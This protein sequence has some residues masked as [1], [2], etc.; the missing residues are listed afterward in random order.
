MTTMEAEWV[1]DMRFVHTSDS[2]HALVTD[3][4]AATG[5]GDTAPSPME[6]VLHGLAGCTGVDVISILRKMKEPV[7][8]LRVVVA[9]ERAD[10]HPRV[11]TRLQLKYVVSG[12]VDENK[13]KRAIG[14]SEKT[15]CSVT[16]MLA[17]TASIDTSYEIRPASGAGPR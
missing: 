8:A 14:L 2:G 5:G 17:K 13:L 6:L 4:A 9:A 15:Y 12:D 11:Y 16:A 7:R 10:E 1:G 3:T